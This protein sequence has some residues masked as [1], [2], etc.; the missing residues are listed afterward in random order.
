MEKG[1]KINEIKGRKMER[2]EGKGR[3]EG[4]IIGI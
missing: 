4:K 2:E 1:E 3:D